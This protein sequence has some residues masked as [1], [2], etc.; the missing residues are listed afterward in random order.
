MIQVTVR[1]MLLVDFLLR[2]LFI[3]C[4]IRLFVVVA[5]PFKACCIVFTYKFELQTESC[6]FDEEVAP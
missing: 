6:H 1:Y 2:E 4:W 3:P 5:A